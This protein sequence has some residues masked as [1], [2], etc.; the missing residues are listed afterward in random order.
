MMSFLSLSIRQSSNPRRLR[1]ILEII[2]CERGNK[3]TATTRLMYQDWLPLIA[4]RP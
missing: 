2:L 1:F 3:G 4:I